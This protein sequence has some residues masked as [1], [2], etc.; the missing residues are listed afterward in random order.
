MSAAHPHPPTPP[1]H[2]SAHCGK[3]DV[4]ATSF[5]SPPSPE[6]QLWPAYPPSPP[7]GWKTGLEPGGDTEG[8]GAKEGRSAGA[9]AC[10]AQSGLAGTS[11]QEAVTATV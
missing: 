3:L 1:A 4:G 6:A 10:R 8:R 5:R 11:L 9:G 7:A 2:S